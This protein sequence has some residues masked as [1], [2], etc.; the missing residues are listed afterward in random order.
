[1]QKDKSFFKTGMQKLMFLG[2]CSK[3]PAFAHV[4]ML[5]NCGPA[6]GEQHFCP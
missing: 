5:T 1:M 2:V 3:K 6:E 4:E